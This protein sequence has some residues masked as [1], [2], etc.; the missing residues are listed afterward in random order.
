MNFYELNNRN[1]KDY[2]KNVKSVESQFKTKAG[3]DGER[4]T[5]DTPGAVE[6]LF[7]VF[8]DNTCAYLWPS[9]LKNCSTDEIVAREVTLTEVDSKDGKHRNITSLLLASHNSLT[10]RCVS[11]DQ[12]HNGRY[13]E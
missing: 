1:P 3:K 7:V 10:F 8:D 11:Y 6:Q 5:P 4:C 9:A 12:L 13:C 2:V